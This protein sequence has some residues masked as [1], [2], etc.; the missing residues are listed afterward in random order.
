MPK[1]VAKVFTFKSSSN[2]NKSYETLLYKD[3]TLSCNCPG[4]TRRTQ[5][6][7]SRICKHIISAG[8]APVSVSEPVGRVARGGSYT[9][10]APREQKPESKPQMKVVRRFNFD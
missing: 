4:W 6:D 9:K 3:G 10:A 1:E 5:P 2:P 7:G 8:Y